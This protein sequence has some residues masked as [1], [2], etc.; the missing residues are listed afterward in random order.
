MPNYIAAADGNFTAGATWASVVE[1]ADG[2]SNSTVL[3][4]AYVASATFTP[5]AVTID[6]IA[7]KIAARNATPSGTMSVRLA[8]AG[9]TVAGTEV[10]IN[11]SDILGTAALQ[12]GWLFFKFA[13]PVL[14]LAATLYTVDAKTSVVS[15]VTLYRTDA[16]AGNWSRMVRT[17]TTGV[18]P[19]AGD[20]MFILGEWTAAS[21]KTNRAV[22]MDSIA[23]TDYGNASTT[24]AS[25][26][27]SNGGTLTWGTT[28]ATNYL[29]RLS[30]LLYVWAGGILNMGTTVTPCPRD[31]SMQLEFDCVADGDFGLIVWGTWN[32]QGQ[33]R[34]AG[35][36]N[37][38][39]LLN[40]DEA[41]G[42][43]V[44]GTDSQL[45]AAN[46]DAIVI[47]STTRTI[48]DCEERVMNGDAG[49]AS[50][51]VTV[52]LT[53][54][55]S[56]T[57][58]TQAEVIS[59]TRAVR[60]LSVSATAMAYVTLNTNC[61]VDLDWMS[62]RY[63]GASIITKR[64]VD[65]RGTAGSVSLNKCSF[66][67]TETSAFHCDLAGGAGGFSV[68]DCVF[69]ALGV[70]GSNYAIYVNQPLS[71]G[72]YVITGN[73]TI[74]NT[75]TSTGF[76]VSDLS[77]TFTGNRAA[78]G[79]NGIAIGSILSSDVPV[80]VTGT[81]D[82]NTV[83][84]CN[85]IGIQVIGCGGGRMSNFTVWR[86]AAG[87]GLSLARQIGDTV[88]DGLVAFGNAT[89][90]VVF[91]AGEIYAN[92]TFKRWTLN[93]DTTFS[94]PV[95]ISVA[96][97]QIPNHRIEASALGVV[98]GIKTAHTTADI[99][100]NAGTVAKFYQLTL[101]S[102]LLASATEIANTVNGVVGKCFIAYQQADDVAGAD[103][104]VV[105]G[106]GTLSRDTVTFRTASPSEKLVPS[107][108][109]AGARFESTPK[110]VA[111]GS[112]QSVTISAYVNKSGGYTGSSP[113][114]RVMENAAAGILEATVATHAGAA[115]SWIQLQGTVGPATEDCWLTFY[116][117]CDGSAGQVNVDDYSAS[118]S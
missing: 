118:V 109:V 98:S 46:G 63:L 2:E 95:G 111:C 70:A 107:G 20:L 71:S 116:V 54:A 86:C 80:K 83:H 74:A 84:S 56:G 88:I 91:I 37:H 97:T 6:G 85:S 11:V 100:L 16:T 42:Q 23:A 106:W 67:N 117:D 78:G 57:S 52:G 43:T 5:G 33:S 77:G 62:F 114:L 25:F 87:A 39:V 102:T 24:L 41:A 29:L 9:A 13:A 27:I 35:S 17:T 72:T 60:V 30:G 104:T 92:N 28:A 65:W 7:V 47:A 50:L 81:I 103:S 12:N 99:S 34:I 105:A 108:A 49:A 1:F 48:T 36:T 31:S 19:I 21:T 96:N 113:R 66:R 32:G 93:G 15:M 10:T 59:L 79:Q 115:G 90:N 22:T 55:H 73:V 61:A 51:T 82:N 68:T 40:T 38:Y 3:T 44:L 4:T 26:G 45:S 94:T 112:G 64:A 8:Q 110:R 76:W 69:W 75:T 101:V 89:A 18:A 14:L 53:S 58:P